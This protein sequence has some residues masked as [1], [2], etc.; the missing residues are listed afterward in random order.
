M[1]EPG[2]CYCWKRHLG[3]VNCVFILRFFLDGYRLRQKIVIW[4]LKIGQ[5]WAVILRLEEESFA[6]M[7]FEKKDVAERVF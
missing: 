6:R 1:L 4:A 7:V 5:L 2:A 3:L